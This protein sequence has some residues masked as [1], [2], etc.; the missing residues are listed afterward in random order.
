MRDTA[1]PGIA[2]PG[3]TLGLGRASAATADDAECLHEASLLII[4]IHLDG[5]AAAR[6]FGG[7]G[8]A[9]ATSLGGQIGADTEEA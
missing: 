3:F 2:R 4:W 1:R 8:R 6:R 7:L 9:V 5:N